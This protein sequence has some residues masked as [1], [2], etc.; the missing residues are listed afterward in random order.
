[1]DGN[2]KFES[3][4]FRNI[5]PRFTQEALAANLELVELLKRIA[6]QKDATVAQIALA[7]ILAPKT[8]DC[9]HS[10]TTKFNRLTENNASVDVRLN[11]EDI[12]AIEYATSQV[13]ITGARYPE[14]LEKTTGL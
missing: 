8:M 4:D 9:A 6:K 7:W 5:L 2:T 10:R 12:K 14:H 13:Q 1:M 11:V 3:G